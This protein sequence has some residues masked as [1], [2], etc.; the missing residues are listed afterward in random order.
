MKKLIALVLAL[1]CMLCFV[2]CSMFTTDVSWTDKDI[3]NA[4]SVEINCYDIQDGSLKVVDVYT[5][6]DEKEVNNICNTFSLLKVKKTKI[7][8]P[9]SLAYSISFL[10][11]SG[12]A[13][14]TVMIPFGWNVIQCG[15]LY[16]ITDEMDINRYIREDVLKDTQN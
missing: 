9:M 7:T 11:G 10:D 15:D 12:N 2:G 4:K 6:V 8:K 14:E 16:K 1:V 13:I 3:K 5:I